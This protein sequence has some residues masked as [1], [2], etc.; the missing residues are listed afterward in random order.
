V[1]FTLLAVVLVLI[2]LPLIA[3]ASP[4]IHF[5]LPES[6]TAPTVTTL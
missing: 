2:L 1:N 3:F 6:T 4:S 5:G